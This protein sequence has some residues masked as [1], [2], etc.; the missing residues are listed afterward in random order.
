MVG[1]NKGGVDGDR[2]FRIADGRQVIVLARV[3]RSAVRVEDGVASVEFNGFS[4]RF[5]GAIVVLCRH[6]LVSGGL[7]LLC[8]CLIFRRG[9]V[10]SRCDRS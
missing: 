8:L 1:L 2:L 10:G 5:N 9:A 6:K 7:Q 3:R 4:V